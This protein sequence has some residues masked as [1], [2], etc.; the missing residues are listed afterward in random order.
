[1]KIKRNIFIVAAVIAIIAV[2][3]SLLNL[4]TKKDPR[5]FFAPGMKYLYQVQFESQDDLKSGKDSAL[6]AA[7]LSG[8]QSQMEL[9]GFLVISG[10]G[11]K[12]KNQ[13]ISLQLANID[14]YDI[15]VGNQKLIPDGASAARLLEKPITFAKLDSKGNFLEISFSQDASSLYQNLMQS[16]MGELTLSLEKD[17][18]SWQT[19]ERTRRGV[20]LVEYTIDES[21]SDSLK[22]KKTKKDYLE[23]V[24]LKRTYPNNIVESAGEIELSDKGHLVSLHTNEKVSVQDGRQAIYDFRSKSK[25]RLQRVENI[26][27]YSREQQ[28]SSFSSSSS[29]SWHGPSEMLIDP[30]LSK[31]N[32]AKMAKGASY[33]EL[34]ERFKKASEQGKVNAKSMGNAMWQ[35]FGLLG[36][37]PTRSAELSELI[38]SADLSP[39]MNKILFTVLSRHDHPEAQSAVR[40]LLNDEGFR[41]LSNFTDMLQ[42]VGFMPRPEPATREAVAKIFADNEGRIKHAAA[43]TIG[44]IARNARQNGEEEAARQ[45]NQLL[46]EELSLAEQPIDQQRLLVSM[47]NSSMESNIPIVEQ[48]TRNDNA[49]TRTAAVMALRGTQTESSERILWDM[50]SDKDTNVQ[51]TALL[52]LSKYDLSGNDFSDLVSSIESGKLSS[53]NYHMVLNLLGG[54]LNNNPDGVG[55]VCDALLTQNISNR[56]L[57]G[58]IM[59][60]KNKVS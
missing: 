49:E 13:Q 9:S 54:N 48:Y 16:V 31:E 12:E 55:R 10:L 42:E 2:G 40:A 24:A 7:G 1:M 20:Q 21:S 5:L 33:S 36:V 27:E 47:A 50:S 37:D 15:S 43:Y 41:S 4:D 19:E 53:D 22:L 30:Q 18:Q 52:M 51:N 11:L 45:L 34:I 17:K 28:L 39:Q 8:M 25:F 60:L 32:F 35:L 58:E 6:A 23:I 57:A 29:A 56:K 14:K 38:R 26:D 3:F 44:T 46:V 59:A